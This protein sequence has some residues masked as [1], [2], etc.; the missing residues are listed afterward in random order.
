MSQESLRFPTGI[1]SAVLIN[2]LH[3]SEAKTPVVV[4][5]VPLETAVPHQGDPSHEDDGNYGDTDNEQMDWRLSVSSISIGIS[6]SA[7]YV[8]LMVGHRL[9]PRLPLTIAIPRPLSH[10]SY[11]C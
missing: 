7:V 5:P 1:A 8:S 4:A 3:G 9:S 11:L 2:V 6:I 10:T